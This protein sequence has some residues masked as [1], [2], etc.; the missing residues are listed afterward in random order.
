MLK[1]KRFE[2]QVGLWLLIRKQLNVKKF[3]LVDPDIMIETNRAGK[4]NLNFSTAA[5]SK[6][7]EAG[8]K[9]AA[10]TIGM[11]LLTLKKIVLE[12]KAALRRK[13]KESAAK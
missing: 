13:S 4:S 10:G 2:V 5:L 6:T 8:K 9:T 12:K 1:I 7:G 11:P 3:I